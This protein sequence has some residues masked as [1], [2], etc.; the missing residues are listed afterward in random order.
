[1][2]ISAIAATAAAIRH[3]DERPIAPPPI[4]SRAGIHRPP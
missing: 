1:M 2:T 4:A 3:I